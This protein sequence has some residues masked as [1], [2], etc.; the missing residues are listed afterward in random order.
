MNACF[1]YLKDTK[2][3][4]HMQAALPTSLPPLLPPSL[5]IFNERKSVGI[6][7]L[8]KYLDTHTHTNVSVS[9]NKFTADEV[10][11]ACAC[12]ERLDLFVTCISRIQIQLQL[13]LISGVK[14]ALF[15]RNYLSDKLSKLFNDTIASHTGTLP[16]LANRYKC[17]CVCIAVGKVSQ[18][19]YL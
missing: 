17:I 11:A 15:S 5:R 16:P 14:C 10:K 19:K 3:T 12:R 13:Q 6:V 18:Q 1:A 9:H 8:S 4:L 2:C 7:R